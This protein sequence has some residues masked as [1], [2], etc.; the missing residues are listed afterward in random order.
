MQELNDLAAKIM[1]AQRKRRHEKHA[2]IY[3]PQ[4]TTASSLGYR[5]E[6]RLVYARTRPEMAVAISTELA[7]IFEEGDLHQTDVRRELLVLGFEALEAERAFRDEKL[8]IAGRIDGMFSMPGDHRSRI[9]VEIKSCSGT[10]PATAEGLRA[11]DGIY[12]R[13]YAQMQ[14]YLVLTSSPGG[15]FLFKDKMMGLWTLVPVALDYEYAERLLKKAERV[16]DHVKAGTL[17]DRLVDRSECGACPFKDTICL[18]AD[19]DVDP[20]LLVNDTELISQ[21]EERERLDLSAT[22]YDKIDKAVKERFRLTCGDRFVVGDANGFLVEKKKH[23][24]GIRIDIRR[25]SQ[26]A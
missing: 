14:T 24:K 22:T 15:I 6:R 8:E 18:P 19:A 13:Y 12:A 7:S 25:L 17:P 11:H 5:C 16:R 1:E 20:M 2:K 26:A 10:P 21:L 4:S 9:P 23:G 3:Q